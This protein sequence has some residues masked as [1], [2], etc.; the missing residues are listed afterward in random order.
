MP[1]IGLLGLLSLGAAGSLRL[2]SAKI[3]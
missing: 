3:K 2:V 1:L